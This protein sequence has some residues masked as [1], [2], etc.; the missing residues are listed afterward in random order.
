MQATQRDYDGN[1]IY[2]WR[3]T[4]P[5]GKVVWTWTATAEDAIAK[6]IKHRGVK[7]VKVEP[8]KSALEER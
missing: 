7:P 6:T 4:M 1:Q 2:R 8:A 3:V 5:D